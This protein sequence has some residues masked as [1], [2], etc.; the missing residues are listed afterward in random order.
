MTPDVP[1]AL[2]RVAGG[3]DRGP[4][5][6]EPAVKWG[7]RGRTRA[8]GH[9]HTNTEEDGNH[10]LSKILPGDRLRLDPSGNVLR[11]AFRFEIMDR[12]NTYII[13]VHQ[14]RLVSF[15]GNEAT[16]RVATQIA[17]QLEPEG[18]GQLCGVLTDTD[19]N[20]VAKIPNGLAV[21]GNTRAW[22]RA[23]DGTPNFDNFVGQT[24]NQGRAKEGREGY[25]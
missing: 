1:S 6:G 17:A 9:P 24:G 12:R 11:P 10:N 21:A 23:V 5:Q 4:H 20:K 7:F 3:S 8:I 13:D 19:P 15:R 14:D 25:T 18:K 22:V 2:E 16:H